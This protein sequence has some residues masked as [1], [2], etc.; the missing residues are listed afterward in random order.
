MRRAPGARGLGLPTCRPSVGPAACEH[1]ANHQEAHRSAG[2]RADDSDCRDA[3]DEPS[4]HDQASDAASNH[5]PRVMGEMLLD[6]CHR[7][8]LSKVP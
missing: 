4:D 8:L 5:V 6:R 7:V 1:H 2:H 3:D